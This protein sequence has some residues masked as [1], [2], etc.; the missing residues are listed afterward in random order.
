MQAIHRAFYNVD[1]TSECSIKVRKIGP[2]IWQ[3]LRRLLLEIR[4]IMVCFFKEHQA[5]ELARK[6]QGWPQYHR[7]SAPQIFFSETRLEYV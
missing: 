4:V 5:R 2:Q 7:L 3:V 6:F 1:R